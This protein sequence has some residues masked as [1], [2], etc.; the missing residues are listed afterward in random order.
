MSNYHSAN[1]PSFGPLAAIIHR[2][3]PNDIQYIEKMRTTLRW[4]DRCRWFGIALHVSLLAAIIWLGYK[5]EL[6]ICEL[7]AAFPVANPNANGVVFVAALVGITFGS[8]FQH[9]VWSVLTAVSGMR[10]ERLMVQ[11]YDEHSAGGASDP[12]GS[13]VHGVR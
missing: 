8:M 3:E 2:R 1:N 7:Q 12:S 4:W 11:L 10:S 6:L 9:S 13:Q 5:F